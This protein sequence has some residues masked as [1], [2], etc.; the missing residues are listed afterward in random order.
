MRLAFL[1]GF[2]ETDVIASQDYI[3]GEIENGCMYVSIATPDQVERFKMKRDPRG[4]ITAQVEVEMRQRLEGEIR[5]KLLSDLAGD[6]SGKIA[7]VDNTADRLSALRA[8][9]G[10]TSSVKDGGTTVTMTGSGLQGPHKLGGI[11]S[12][13]DLAGGATGSTSGMTGVPGKGV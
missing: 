13:N 1:D 4:T 6:D 3:E 10:E 5:E 11:V 8:R 12:T 2:L 9:L 7:G